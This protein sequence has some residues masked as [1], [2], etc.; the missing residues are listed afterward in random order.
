MIAIGTIVCLLHSRK[1]D[2][3]TIILNDDLMWHLVVFQHSLHGWYLL[4]GKEKLLLKD[5]VSLKRRSCSHFTSTR[6]ESHKT[7]T[8]V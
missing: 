3:R 7:N 6:T 1:E 5:S 2:L 8:A 4:Q